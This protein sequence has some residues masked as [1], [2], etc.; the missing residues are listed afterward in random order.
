MIRV[1]L[2][3]KLDKCPDFWQNYVIAYMLSDEFTL[4]GM[5]VPTV[6]ERLKVYNAQYTRDYIDDD[7]Y[8]AYIEFQDE[9]DYTWFM[10]VWS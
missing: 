9:K 7:E 6:N 3:S 5:S 2:G 10:L 8:M 1:E 4:Y